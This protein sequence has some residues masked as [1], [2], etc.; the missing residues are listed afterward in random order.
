V[1]V[2]VGGLGE[3]TF[4]YLHLYAVASAPPP[5]YKPHLHLSLRSTP[6]PSHNRHHL[7]RAKKQP[8][9]ISRTHTRSA[10]H[11]YGFPHAHICGPIS[12]NNLSPADAQLASL[13]IVT[14]LFPHFLFSLLT[15]KD[16]VPPYPAPSQA[17]LQ[18]QAVQ[19]TSQKTSFRMPAP[20]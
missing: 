5:P 19:T 9:P 2:R 17:P 6:P 1:G 20:T 7:P 13:N 18:W 14:V 12:S 10:S 4:T 8:V 16:A 15:L 11:N 3:V